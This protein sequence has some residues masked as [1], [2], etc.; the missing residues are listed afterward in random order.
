MGGRG[1]S[2]LSPLVS[3]LLPTFHLGLTGGR[4]RKGVGEQQKRRGGRHGND[5]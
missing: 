4:R 3:L 5:Y 2:F 1:F